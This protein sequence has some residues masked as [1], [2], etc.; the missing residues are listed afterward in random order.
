M[1]NES[2][3]QCYYMH[4]SHHIIIITYLLIPTYHTYDI[5][6]NNNNNNIIITY[7][8]YKVMCYSFYTYIL[9]NI[10]INVGV[11]AHNTYRYVIWVVVVVRFFLNFRVFYYYCY[12]LFCPVSTADIPSYS[13]S[14]DLIAHRLSWTWSYYNISFFCVSLYLGDYILCIVYIIL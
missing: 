8:R 5:M 10:Y 4:T 9:H 11:G 3:K 7:I 1:D 6:P 12:F 13:K 14:P 2:S